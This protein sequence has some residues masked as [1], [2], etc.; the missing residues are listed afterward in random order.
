MRDA[1][2]VDENRHGAEGFLRGIKGARHRRAVGDIGLDSDRFAALAFD[3]VFERLEAVGPPRHQ[4]DGGAVVG[5]R[6][7]ELRAEPAGRAGHQR[8]AAF[9]AE[10]IRGLHAVTLYTCAATT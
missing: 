6:F 7:G 8:H 5:Q 1:G 9:Q 2:I 10:H 3:L 4:R